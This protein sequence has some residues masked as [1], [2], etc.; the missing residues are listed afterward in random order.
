ME[1][2]LTKQNCYLKTAWTRNGTI[3]TD[4]PLMVIT[5]IKKKK[6]AAEARP[7]QL[8]CVG[9]VFIQTHQGLVRIM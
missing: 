5:K 8:F 6:L 2:Q 4:L 7:G 3:R 1:K 9:K